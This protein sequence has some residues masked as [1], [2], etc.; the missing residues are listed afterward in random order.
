MNVS[1]AVSAHAFGSA[2]ECRLYAFSIGISAADSDAFVERHRSPDW[3]T[4]AEG[5]WKRRAEFAALFPTMAAAAEC[6]RDLLADGYEGDLSGT[7]MDYGPQF[8]GPK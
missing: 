1:T 7:D 8:R 5:A 6:G 3:T 4:W 2:T